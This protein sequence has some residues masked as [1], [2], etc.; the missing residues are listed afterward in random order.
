MLISSRTELQTNQD[1]VD[2]K[3]DLDSLCSELRTKA[4]CSE[5]GMTI[6]KEHVDAA[7]RKLG[8]KT[9]SQDQ[10]A[11]IFEQDSW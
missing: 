11:L 1:F 10:S 4:K 9:K 8:E 7:L 5:S 3:F 2:G 6:P